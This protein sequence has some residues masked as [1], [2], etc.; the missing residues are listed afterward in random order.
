V[1][2]A[3]E[4][5]YEKTSFKNLKNENFQIARWS[6]ANMLVLP[7]AEAIASDLRAVATKEIE[8]VDK[9]DEIDPVETAPDFDIS[10]LVRNLPYSVCVGP[11]WIPTSDVPPV[12]RS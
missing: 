11:T 6:Q 5:T 9:P 12:Q 4:L 10:W 7:S 3:V 1:S 8:L 2:A